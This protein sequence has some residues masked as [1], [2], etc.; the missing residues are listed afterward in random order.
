MPELPDVE[1]FKKHMDATSLHH[2]IRDV[3]V[4]NTKV[5]NSISAKKLQNKLKDRSFESTMRYGKYL[6]AK[7]D[8][9]FWLVLHFGMTGN[10]KYFKNKRRNI[11]YGRILFCF[12]NDYTLAYISQRM[13]GKVGLTVSVEEF[14]KDKSWGPDALDIEHDVFTNTGSVKNLSH[15]FS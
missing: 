11:E 7:T 1:I 13:L 8:E 14:I 10:L 12:T 5:L 4:I 2:K 3:F 15:F 6:F 9:N